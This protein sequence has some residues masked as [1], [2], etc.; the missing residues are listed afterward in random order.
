M[1]SESTMTR[2]RQG[3]VEGI[4]EPNDKIMGLMVAT[5]FHRSDGPNFFVRLMHISDQEVIIQEGAVVGQFIFVDEVN[6]TSLVDDKQQRLRPLEIKGMEMELSHH[7]KDHFREWIGH[8][9]VHGQSVL[10]A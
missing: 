9:K 4:I 2:M 5:S 7:L 8:L 1:D 3:L 6:A 10:I